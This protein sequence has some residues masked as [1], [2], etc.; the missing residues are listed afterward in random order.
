MG[1]QAFCIVIFVFY[2]IVLLVDPLRGYEHGGPHGEL[3][4]D[5]ADTY[6]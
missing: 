6:M 4:W 3:S 1:S 2:A 5:N